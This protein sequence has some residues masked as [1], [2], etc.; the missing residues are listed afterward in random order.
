MHRQDVS[1]MGRH[2]LYN[3]LA[4]AVAARIMEVRSDVIRES[5]A[6]FQGVPH[7]LEFVREVDGVRYFNDS[8]ATNVNAAWYALESFSERI[9]LIAGGRDKGNDYDPLRGLVRRKVRGLVAIGEG[10]DKIVAELGPETGTAVKSASLAEAVQTARLI[11][12]PGDIVLLSPACA[13]FD[14]FENYEDRGDTFKRI[15]AEL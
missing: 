9:V 12:K 3:T 10:A 1:L 7:R 2:N 5:M 11:A 8:K 15:V 14:Q 4:A 6:T 13:S